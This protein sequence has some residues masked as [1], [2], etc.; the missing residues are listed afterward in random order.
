MDF[1]ER[2]QALRAWEQTDTNIY[3]KGHALTGGTMKSTKEQ[4]EASMTDA[5]LNVRELNDA[6]LDLEL[7]DFKAEE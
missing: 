7:Q 3:V 1:E 4:P 6:K 5:T 2:R